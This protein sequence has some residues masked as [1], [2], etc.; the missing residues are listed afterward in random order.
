MDTE[1]AEYAITQPVVT[2]YLTVLY[3]RGGGGR[4]EL[5]PRCDIISISGDVYDFLREIRKICG[6][7]VE[8]VS[9]CL[10]IRFYN[11]W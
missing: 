5:V 6:G 9:L 3:I 4:G 8:S 10:D 11:S 1:R 7:V 2:K